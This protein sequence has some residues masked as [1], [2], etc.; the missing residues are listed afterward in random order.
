MSLLIIRR[1]SRSEFEAL[2][3]AG[4]LISTNGYLI[5]DEYDTLEIP[6]LHITSPDPFIN[7]VINVSFT[8]TSF[9]PFMEVLHA[10]VGAPSLFVTGS[11]GIY[12]V[13]GAQRSDLFTNHLWSAYASQPSTRAS[14][15]KND[16]WP[17]AGGGNL[18]FGSFSSSGSLKTNPT[19]D[20]RIHIVWL[21][22]GLY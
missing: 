14:G 6:S 18:S 22:A 20:F 13:H 8:G 11:N 1:V 9:L 7:Q 5:T 3:L 4:E 19:E 10:D 15:E 16:C 17:L 21:E 12:N 2:K